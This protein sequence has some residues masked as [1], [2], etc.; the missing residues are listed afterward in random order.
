MAEKSVDMLVSTELKN[1]GYTDSDINYGYS[2]PSTGNNDFTP[3]ENQQY[4]SKSLQNTRSEFEF[5]IFN[6]YR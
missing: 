2:L 5:L 3:I 1:V 6:F 4:E